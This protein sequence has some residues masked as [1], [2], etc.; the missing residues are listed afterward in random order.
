MLNPAF[1]IFESHFIRCE[2]YST[3]YQNIFRTLIVILT[4]VIGI[5]SIGRFDDMLSL[6]GCAVCTPIA[7]IFPS[8]FH[9]QIFKNIQS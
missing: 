1:N 9:F 8:L 2:T 4:V 6:V 5:L 7:L 3:L